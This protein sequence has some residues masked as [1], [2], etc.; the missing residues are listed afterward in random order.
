M[1]SISS[2]ASTKWRRS[3]YYKKSNTS[4]NARK[5]LE[6]LI[7][8]AG[9]TKPAGG[10]NAGSQCPIESEVLT[11]VE[12]RLDTYR[13]KQVESHF[14]QCGE[15]REFLALFVRASREI[16]ERPREFAGAIHES[17]VSGQSAKVLA[18]IE[19]D[20]ANYPQN[21]P[22]RE[23]VVQHGGYRISFPKLA[24]VAGAVAIIVFASAVPF[25]MKDPPERLSHQALAEA[26]KSERQTLGRISGSFD[27]S[28]YSK[29]VRG[30]APSTSDKPEASLQFQRAISKLQAV[31][32]KDG[33][34]DEKLALARAYLAQNTKGD[35]NHA[36]RIMRQLS[37]NG[38][39]TAE[40]DNDYGVALLEAK[41]NEGALASFK[42]ALEKRPDFYEAMFNKA[43]VNTRLDRTADAIADWNAFLRLSPEEGWKMEARQRLQDLEKANQ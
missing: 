2:R 8:T 41:D 11:Y 4:M 38:F 10:Q 3:E 14:A 40:F 43:L 15:C 23:A 25:L 36:L 7:G 32:K 17:E 20:D 12:G 29:D 1:E 27:R 22:V 24:L 9:A 28:P 31:E 18:M 30:S 39:E 6:L 33:H 5:L 13:R 21:T 19:T 26:M 16:A 35:L 42:R 37:G 34:L